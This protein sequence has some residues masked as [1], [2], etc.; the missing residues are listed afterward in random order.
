MLIQQMHEVVYFLNGIQICHLSDVKKAN[1][2]YPKKISPEIKAKIL[3]VVF[4]ESP[5]DH[6][7]SMLIPKIYAVLFP[8]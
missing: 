5:L 3:V 4:G 1:M 6:V 7:P 8:K 2:R